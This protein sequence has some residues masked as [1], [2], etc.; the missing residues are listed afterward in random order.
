MSLFAHSGTATFDLTGLKSPETPAAWTPT[1]IPDVSKL[2]HTTKG[3]V[4]E[5]GIHHPPIDLSY[6]V[7]RSFTVGPGAGPV[8]LNTSTATIFNPYLSAY[9]NA[10]GSAYP[11]YTPPAALPVE[12]REMP[13][14]GYRAWTFSPVW[15]LGWGKR[16][17][18][19]ALNAHLGVWTDKDNHAICHPMGGNY[20]GSVGHK[21]PD[22]HCH[23]GF[24]VLADLDQVMGHVTMADNI[25]V[26]AVMGWGKVVQHGKEGWRAEH[27]K[28]IALLDCK[29]SDPQ[30]KNTQAAAKSYG[31]EIKE[32]SQLEALIG[33]WGDPL[34]AK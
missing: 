12:K 32:R 17:S 20:F 31:L 28:I 13:V 11:T 14:I 8:Y 4:L 6:L 30:S 27:A 33:E 19:S 21:A 10:L 7:A 24:Y 3:W 22:E 5:N 15:K 26:G 9:Q 16:G 1:P 25:V 2:D 23:C 34:E 18:L 29:Y